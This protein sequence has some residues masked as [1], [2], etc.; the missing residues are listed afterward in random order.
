MR[1]HASVNFIV[2]KCSN[3]SSLKYNIIG[4]YKVYI[5]RRFLE[6]KCVIITGK[7]IESHPFLGFN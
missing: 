1:I 5:I 6:I 4:N 3:V 2:A 7:F